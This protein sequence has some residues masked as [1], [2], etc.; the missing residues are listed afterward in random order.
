[1]DRVKFAHGFA[2]RLAA[3]MQEKGHGTD[4]S[5]AGIDIQTLAKITGSSY[6]M[7]RKYAMGDVLPEPHIILKIAKWLDTP[8]SWLLFGDNPATS[9]NP[10]SLDDIVEIDQKLL[11]YI[12][13]KC[14]V[15]LEFSNN[16][17]DALDFILETIYD[18]SHLNADNETIYKIVDMMVSSANLVHK[19]YKDSSNH[20]EVKPNT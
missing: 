9:A 5:K 3:V 20:E 12:L 10:K 13:D 18:A 19:N 2:R 7:A 17:D 16:K 15:F 8:P 4:R 6:Q 14:S 11:R 1:M